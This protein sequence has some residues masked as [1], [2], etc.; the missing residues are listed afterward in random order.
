MYCLLIVCP[1]VGAAPVDDSYISWSWLSTRLAIMVYS[2]ETA[3]I[4]R[5]L[6]K[7]QLLWLYDYYGLYELYSS[8][9]A[10]V[11]WLNLNQRKHKWEGGPP[12]TT[13]FLRNVNFAEPKEPYDKVLMSLGS[14]SREFLHL[15]LKMELP[16]A[17]ASFFHVG[18]P[19]LKINLPFWDGLESPCRVSM[20][21]RSYSPTSHVGITS[22]M[23]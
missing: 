23:W 21:L 22:W 19:K 6:G 16:K 9:I 2:N 20:I 15:K 13:V 18:N 12:C 8:E 11:H 14:R 5:S 7:L 1:D 3:V 17:K 10:I 4:E